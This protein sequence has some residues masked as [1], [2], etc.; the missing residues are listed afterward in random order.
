MI[1]MVVVW[2]IV[3]IIMIVFEII[4]L[5]L[6]SIW[7]AGGAL[8]ALILAAL[9]LPLWLQIVAFV[10]ASILLLFITR[11]IAKKYLNKHVTKTN[12][13]SLIG[14][15]AVVSQDIDNIMSTGEAM[16]NGMPWMAR[17]VDD[18]TK[19]LKG[20]LV[21]ITDIQGVKLIVKAEE[22]E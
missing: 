18:K 7:F 21:K 12:A 22:N 2:L 15:T 6:T 11:P 10:V 9:K 17:S 8:V 16:I 13:E 19:I 14:S 5:G 4:S 3:M 1:S 20:T